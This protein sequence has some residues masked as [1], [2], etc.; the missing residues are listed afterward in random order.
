[1]SKSM[2]HVHKVPRVWS[3]REL[4]KFA[5]LFE[6]TVVNV[7]GWKDVDKEGRHY[8]D[9]FTG[10]TSYSITNFKAEARGFQGMEGEIFLDL[11]ADLP[12]DLV[13]AFDVVFNHT[14]LEH[15]Y[16]A[17]KA[18]ANL[19]RLS[20]D[21]VIIV[22]PF[23]QQYHS[24]YGDYWRFSPLATKRMFEDNGY[25][26]VYQSFNSDRASSVYT[27]SIGTRHPERWKDQFDWTFTCVDPTGR[28]SEPYIGCHA[29]PRHGSRFNNFLRKL[30]AL[31]DKILG[32]A[33]S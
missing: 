15:I 6:G 33:R 23:L 4:A 24:D 31:P 20:G 22:L 12:A 3:N 30:A 32:R 27:F 16:E 1:M 10:A 19:C 11:E 7:S 14:T 5:H 25:T 8:R 29:I 13:G 2:D 26:L 18:F 9:Y 21:I 28:G 17:R